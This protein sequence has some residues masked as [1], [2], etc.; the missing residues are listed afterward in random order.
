MQGAR[1]LTEL[2]VRVGGAGSLE[3][4]GVALGQRFAFLHLQRQ[5]ER[6]QPGDGVERRLGLLEGQP[7][8][9]L[10]ALEA[11]GPQV[12]EHQVRLGR[13]GAFLCASRGTVVRVD[14]ARDRQV[15]AGKGRRAV[16]LLE[17]LEIRHDLWQGERRY[18]F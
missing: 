6:V 10:G 12:L 7:A 8:R 14:A 4:E 11:T 17:Y 16:L 13:L 5:R 1:G 15:D 2:L 18:F 9:E 3:E